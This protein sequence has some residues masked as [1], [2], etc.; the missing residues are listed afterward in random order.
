MNPAYG[1]KRGKLLLGVKCAVLGGVRNVDHTGKDH[2]VVGIV[3]IKG[4]EVVFYGVGAE[5]S[6]CM[7]QGN[8]L[9]PRCLN[10]ARLVEC[11]VSRVCGDHTLKIAQ[12][13]ADDHAVGLRAACH[14]K[15]LG[16]GRVAGRLYLF[17]G[18]LTVFV[19]SVARKRLVVGIQ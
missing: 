1:R 15:D 8:Y 7:G 4:F 18:A 17:L 9:V 6:V 16:I 10:G 19:V 5:L 12:H 11:N 14:K 2:V 3:G 13:R